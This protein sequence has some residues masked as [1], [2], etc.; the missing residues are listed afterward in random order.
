M[1]VDVL[2][3]G[4]SGL[5][6]IWLDEVTCFGSEV[7]LSSCRHSGWGTNNCVHSEDAGVR[8]L[9]SSGKICK[10]DGEVHPDITVNLCVED[11][12]V[13]KMHPYF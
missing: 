9:S 4:G 7:M 12:P 6:P 2:I 11:A 3:D 1:G 13:Y 10:L 8:C 5:G